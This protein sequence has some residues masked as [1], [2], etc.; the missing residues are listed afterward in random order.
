M[1]ALLKPIL[2]CTLYLGLAPALAAEEPKADP[3]AQAQSA[4]VV[5]EAYY[6]IRWG[7]DREFVALFE[8]NHLPILEEAMARGLVRDIKIDLPYTHMV[9]GPRWDFRVRTTY[10]DA[11]A[12]MLTDPA[13]IAVFNDMEA[14]LKKANPKFDEEETRRF[15]LLEE[16]WDVVLVSQ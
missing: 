7:S 10:R 6:R 13:W 1:R 5:V 14:R 4:P 15:S 8:K 12:A 9:G 11:A 16:H 3:A 2:F